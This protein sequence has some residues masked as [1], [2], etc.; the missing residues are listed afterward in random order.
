MTDIGEQIGALPMH[1]DKKGNLRILMVTSRDTGRWVMPKGWL[2]DGKRPWAAA[3][4]EA[5]EEAGAVGHIGHEVIGTF[6]Y[7]KG[8]DDGSSLPCRVDVYPMIVDKLKRRWK[9]RNERRR[10]WFTPKAAAKRVQEPE[11]ERMLLSLVDKPQKQPVIK[12]LLKQA[13]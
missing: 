7:D 12:Q 5:L 6:H 13:G 9:E 4:I 1:W 10:H 2:M 11:L 3:E 8:L